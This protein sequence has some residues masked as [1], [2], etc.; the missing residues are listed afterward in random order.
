MMTISGTQSASH[1]KVSAQP[2]ATT[3]F[4]DKELLSVIRGLEEWRHILEG[5][6]HTIEILNDHRKPHIFSNSPDTELFVRPGGP[7][8]LSRFD[9]SLTHRAGR[10]STKPDTLSRHV[11][12]PNR[13]GR[14]RRSDHAPGG[15]GFAPKPLD[16]SKQ[17]PSHRGIPCPHRN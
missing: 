5:T 13:R 6:K 17:T 1:L 14:Q 12:P 11:K 15:S 8:Y 16:P 4:Y 2:N 3:P 10:H 7:L 9:Y